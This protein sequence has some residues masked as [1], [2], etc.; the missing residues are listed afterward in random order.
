VLAIRSL[1]CSQSGRQQATACSKSRQTAQVDQY[2]SL[3]DQALGCVLGN[4]FLDIRQCTPQ[5]LAMYDVW[6]VAVYGGWLHMHS[7]GGL[8]YAEMSLRLMFLHR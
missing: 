4:G 6:L 1:V 5:D 3:C 8:I 2:N 7:L